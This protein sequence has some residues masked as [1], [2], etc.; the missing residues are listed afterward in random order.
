LCGHRGAD[1]VRSQDSMQMGCEVTTSTEAVGCCT[2]NDFERCNAQ[3]SDS[4][5]DKMSGCEWVGGEDAVC[6]PNEYQQSGCCTGNTLK[7]YEMCSAVEDQVTCDRKNKCN[8][9]ETEDPTDCAMTSSTSTTSSAWMAEKPEEEVSSQHKTKGQAFKKDNA[10]TMLFGERIVVGEAH[11]GTVS[12]STVFVLM[13]AAFALQYAVK[14]WMRKK[15][16]EKAND[17][18]IRQTEMAGYFQE[19]S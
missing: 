10:E 8:W 12:L 6:E 19:T 16:M 3:T 17:D 14:W 13:M 2:G 7:S 5:C 9:V 11:E 4:R 18:T 15:A 1:I